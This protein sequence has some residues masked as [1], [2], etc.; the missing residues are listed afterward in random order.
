MRIIGGRFRGRDLG[1]VPHGVRPTSDRVRESLFSMLGPI[2][3]SQV[4]DLF[5]GTGALGIE[6]LSRG[7]RRAVFVDQSRRVLRALRDR[8]ATLGLAEGEEFRTISADAKKA[9]NRLAKEE[10]ADRFDLVFLDA[11]YEEGD[12]VGTLEALFASGILS[13]RARVVVEGPRRHPLPP[14]SGVHVLDERDY[15]D[16]RLTWL[17]ASAPTETSEP[18]PKEQR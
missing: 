14:L 13:E 2:D 7:A 5:A 6:S 12:R 11:P 1:S 10:T 9:I 18:K 15:G 16:T 4:L 8:I 17:A 3:G